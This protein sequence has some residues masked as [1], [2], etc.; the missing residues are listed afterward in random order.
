MGN[1]LNDDE[2]NEEEKAPVHEEV[3]GF[4]IKTGHAIPANGHET[5]KH[6]PVIP[7]TSH[8]NWRDRPGVIKERHRGKN[9][10]PREVQAMQEAE[11]TGIPIGGNNDETEGPSM[12][13]G[14]S[15]AEPQSQSTT[16]ETRGDRSTPDTGQE[17]QPLTQDDIAVRALIQESRGDVER[18]SDLVIE[19]RRTANDGEQDDNANAD[20][21]VYDETSSLRTDVASR[22]ESASLDAYNN[23]PVEEFGAALLRGMG[24]KEGQPV[25]RG[26]YGSASDRVNKPRLPQRRPGL[27]G[28]GARQLPGSK[29]AEAEI[30]AWGKDA[31][32]KSSKRHGRGGESSR[33]RNRDGV[34]MP[35]RAVRDSR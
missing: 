15:Y 26:R 29:G 5:K 35:V 2:Y 13:Y 4:D 12:S 10:L 6:E 25:G 20:T 11:R 7:V 23:I 17:G 9:L 21:D 28:L 32:R 33:D 19:S 1:F 18:R 27:L 16:S 3:T 34:Y 14:L 24:W 30:G 31:M 22:P 8:N